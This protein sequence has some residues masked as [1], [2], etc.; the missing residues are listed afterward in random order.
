[1]TVLVIFDDGEEIFFVDFRG[2]NLEQYTSLESYHGK[3]I[4]SGD[5]PPEMRDFFYNSRGEF[6]F[7]KMG[8][9]LR[10]HPGWDLVMCAGLIGGSL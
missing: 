4:N 3:Y 10:N 2:L 8:E 7:T 5:E 6:R 1:M 9:P